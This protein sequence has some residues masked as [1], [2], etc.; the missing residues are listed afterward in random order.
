MSLRPGKYTLFNRSMCQEW[1]FGST[2]VFRTLFWRLWHRSCKFSDEYIHLLL[3]PK[4]DYLLAKTFFSNFQINLPIICQ[5]A[6]LLVFCFSIAYSICPW[7]LSAFL[8][9]FFNGFFAFSEIICIFAPASSRKVNVHWHRGYIEY[10]YSIL[11]VLQPKM[12]DQHYEEPR[13]VS[14]PMIG[15]PLPFISS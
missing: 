11:M 8:G 10:T 7:S 3:W 14:T 15:V 2:I 13:N 1:H 5:R 9:N 6:P 12:S 4:K